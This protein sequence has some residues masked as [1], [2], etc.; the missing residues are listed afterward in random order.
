MLLFNKENSIS[1]SN[2]LREAIVE[3]SFYDSTNH[4]E[5]DPNIEWASSSTSNITKE[6]SNETGIIKSSIDEMVELVETNLEITVDNYKAYGQYYTQSDIEPGIHRD[7]TTGFLPTYSADHVAILYIGHDG[8]NST[9]E[10]WNHEEHIPS[11]TSHLEH[12]I[13]LKQNDFVIFN[14]ILA[15]RFKPSTWGNHAGDSGLMLAVF[16]NTT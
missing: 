14:H 16:L 2:A 6:L 3:L 11:Y 12:S 15:H 7:Y 1:D 8:W 13:D 9:L 10:F 5:K 4:P